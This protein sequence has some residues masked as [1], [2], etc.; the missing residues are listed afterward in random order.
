MNFHFTVN[1][2]LVNSY[3]LIWC[4]SFQ[5]KFNSGISSSSGLDILWVAS[6]CIFS[7]FLLHLHQRISANRSQCKSETFSFDSSSLFIIYY[8]NNCWWGSVISKLRF[9]YSIIA[10]SLMIF[11]YQQSSC[12]KIVLKLSNTGHLVLWQ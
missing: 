7:L 3:F 2:C 12:D 4:I 9:S 11:I 1:Q 8:A 5:C 10:L 6:S